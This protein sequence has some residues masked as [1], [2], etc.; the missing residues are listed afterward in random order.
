MLTCSLSNKAPSSQSSPK[1][2]AVVKPSSHKTV[3][4]Q[5]TDRDCAVLYCNVICPK[6]KSYIMM[7]AQYNTQS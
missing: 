7:I 4:Q 3:E 5:C 2:M 6:K 1:K